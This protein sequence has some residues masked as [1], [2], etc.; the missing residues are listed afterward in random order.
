MHQP[1]IATYGHG[2]ENDFVILYDPEDSIAVS[3]SAIAA[4]CNRASGIGAD[5]FI[6]INAHN[7]AELGLKSTAD[8]AKSKAGTGRP[9]SKRARL[10]VEYLVTDSGNIFAT[11]IAKSPS[12]L[13]IALSCNRSAL[14]YGISKN[15]A[16][17][18]NMLDEKFNLFLVF[19]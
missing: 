4:M 15:N 2:T 14:K 8:L 17:K 11:L 12:P 10:K 13:F 18:I 3:Q 1:V 7:A 6:R 19:L 5:G 9:E 16:K